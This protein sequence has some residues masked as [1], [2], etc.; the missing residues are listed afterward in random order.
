MTAGNSKKD[1]SSVWLA[2][3]AGSFDTVRV[4]IEIIRSSGHNNKNIYN[5]QMLVKICALPLDISD[6]I[7]MIR[8]PNGTCTP[9]RN[10]SE[11]EK[12]QEYFICLL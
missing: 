9:K 7:I 2:H 6:I 5:E 10:I 12:S 4:L 11:K 3:F 1:H 8:S